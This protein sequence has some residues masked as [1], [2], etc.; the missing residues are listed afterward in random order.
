[1]SNLVPMSGNVAFILYEY[2]DGKKVD[3]ANHT[4]AANRQKKIIHKVQV[5]VNEVAAPLPCCSGENACSLTRL[6]SCFHKS[7]S[8]CDFE[9]LC[10]TSRRGKGKGG[11]KEKK[12]GAKK[13]KKKTDDQEGDY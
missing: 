8:K 7:I 3:K 11:K 4:G 1:M 13:S 5:L 2:D 9:I 10:N 12:K 6:Q